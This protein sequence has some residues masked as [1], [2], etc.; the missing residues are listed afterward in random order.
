MHSRLHC[1]KSPLIKLAKLQEITSL[2]TANQKQ[3]NKQ[4]T[5]QN[6]N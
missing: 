2:L 3:T 6:K 1:Y 5:K 4:K